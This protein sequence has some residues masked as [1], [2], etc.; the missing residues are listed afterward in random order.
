M[1]KMTMEIGKTYSN[2]VKVVKVIVIHVDQAHR[3][4]EVRWASNGSI[5]YRYTDRF[6]PESLWSSYKEI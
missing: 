6:I 3:T 4:V 2:G 1:N 5:P